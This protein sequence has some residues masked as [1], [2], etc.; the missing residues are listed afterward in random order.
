MT[1]E[2]PVTNNILEDLIYK[3]IKLNTVPFYSIPFG[4]VLHNFDLYIHD[5]DYFILYTR[6]PDREGDLLKIIKQDKVL[7]DL[8]KI[9]LDGFLLHDSVSGGAYRN[10]IQLRHSKLIEFY[11]LDRDSYAINWW[12]LN[13]E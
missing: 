8:C 6:T 4:T 5:F 7:D 3:Y 11:N 13:R 1:R 12:V 10:N 2:I 9:N